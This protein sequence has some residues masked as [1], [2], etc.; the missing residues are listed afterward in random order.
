MIDTFVVMNKGATE[1]EFTLPGEPS[2]YRWRLQKNMNQRHKV[3][4]TISELEKDFYNSLR[5]NDDIFS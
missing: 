2:G 5:E 4:V 1:A 3:I